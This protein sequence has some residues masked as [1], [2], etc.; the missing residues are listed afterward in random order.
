MKRIIYF[1]LVLSLGMLISCGDDT[2]EADPNPIVTQQPKAYHEQQ[3]ATD[4]DLRANIGDTVMLHLEASGTH[5]G[6][7]SGEGH[8]SIPFYYD[9]TYKHTIC[10]A[11][12]EEDTHYVVIYN[13][14]DEEIM[15]IAAGECKTEIMPE[16]HYRKEIHHAEEGTETEHEIVFIRP[17][18]RPVK[19][20]SSNYN[21]NPE[22]KQP[23]FKGAIDVCNG[24]C[25]TNRIAA[26][27]DRNLQEGEIAIITGSCPPADTDQVEVYSEPC[28]SYDK[29]VTG[30]QVGK[31]TQLLAFENSNMNGKMALYKADTVNSGKIFCLPTALDGDGKPSFVISSI[32]DNAAVT[33]ELEAVGQFC[34]DRGTNT[35]DGTQTICNPELVSDSSI[36]AVNGEVTIV[37]QPD[38]AYNTQKC[39][40]PAYKFKTSCDDLSLVGIDDAMY[41]IMPGSN[42]T[43]IT[44]FSEPHFGGLSTRIDHEVNSGMDV[45]GSFYILPSGDDQ[46]NAAQG[47]ISSLDIRTNSEVGAITLISTKVCQKCNFVGMDLHKQMLNGAVV[48]GSDFTN[49]NLTYAQFENASMLNATLIGVKANY[50]NFKNAYMNNVT[51]TDSDDKKTSASFKF[52]YFQG[53]N[54][55][56]ATL[57]YA[58]FDNAQ[59]IDSGDSSTTMESAKLVGAYFNNAILKNV[60]LDGVTIAKSTFSNA[61]I[62]NSTM[63]NIT[64]NSNSTDNQST[65]S[66]AILYGTSFTNSSFDY[67]D[68]SNAMISFVNGSY[69]LTAYSSFDNLNYRYHQETTNVNYDATYGNGM[70]SKTS[71]NTECPDGSFGPCIRIGGE[72]ANSCPEDCAG[73]P[74]CSTNWNCSLKTWTDFS[75]KGHW[76]C[77]YGNCEICA[78]TANCGNNYCNILLGE[79]LQSCSSD[80]RNPVPPQCMHGSQCLSRS[81]TLEDYGHWECNSKT[82]HAVCVA[83]SDQD[84]SAGCGD[85]VCSPNGQWMPQQPPIYIGRNDMSTWVNPE[86]NV[87]SNLQ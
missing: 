46:I 26:Y 40:I 65:F 86:Q 45:T 21:D 67:V 22:K 1:S 48:N 61:V 2:T 74:E 62:I 14:Q 56:S 32:S 44:V 39:C 6:D 12:E 31:M 85:N 19:N 75:I 30:V 53:V 69:Q 66:G 76:V 28:F 34:L 15:T 79:T 63:T 35:T 51:T 49:A 78:D 4:S 82:G 23:K 20:I 17:H 84:N 29:T 80:C 24:G 50:A 60:N 81:W 58:H 3:F 87:C 71:P 68:F 47:T 55:T 70:P 42:S 27:K 8:D 16:G 57:N 18:N 5:E 43:E 59:F 11:D 33:C 13:E 41:G 37:T 72:T 52:G 77:E 64:D 73:E 36:S 83:V 7:L 54:L 9:K 25:S 10:V 38:M